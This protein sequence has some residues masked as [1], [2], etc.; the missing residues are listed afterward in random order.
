MWISPYKYILSLGHLCSDINQSI[1]SAVLPFLIA[2]YHYDYTTAAMLV[3]VSNVFGAFVQPF[4]GMLSDK[5]NKLLY[6]TLGVLL[7]SGGMAVTGFIS[8][9]FG[10]WIVVI[11][12]GIG[13]AMFHPQAAKLFNSVPSKNA[14]GKG[15][16]IF[17]FGGK[18]GF[19]LGP[20]YTAFLMNLFGMKGTIL[21]LIP[22][23]VFGIVCSFF[24]K[25]FENLDVLEVEKK[26]EVKSEQNDDWSGFIKLCCV[27]F[28]RSI[29]S[30]GIST[31]LAFYFI[32]QFSKSN[33]FASML[34]SVF[35]G[36]GSITFLG[37]GIADCFGHRKMVRLSF[38]IFLPA[39]FIFT[40]TSHFVIAL[41]ML[42]FMICGESLS[43]SPMVVLEQKYIPNHTGF[44]SGITLGLVVSIGAALCPVLGYVSDAY[45]LNYAFIIM[46]IV[47]AIALAC[48][49]LLPNVEEK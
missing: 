22:G 41:I 15:M 16:S 42:I 23:I 11:M 46:T 38:C 8:N 44:A 13:V 34:L 48:S 7:A 26:E 30:N 21:F 17:S 27:V 3:T 20:V 24:D 25:D 1:L 33:S 47:C 28:S 32:Q 29:L 4:I 12:S 10:L 18:V 19:T 39:I 9:F 2:T 35:Y 45:G 49:M 43:Y 36:I 5:K 40:N 31:F 6:M 37:G 14:K